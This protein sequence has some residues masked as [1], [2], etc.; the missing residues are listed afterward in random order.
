MSDR[1]GLQKRGHRHGDVP[2]S[3]EEKAGREPRPKGKCSGDFAGRATKK[4]SRMADYYALIARTVV[5]L[6]VN[7]EATRR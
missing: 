3:T 7:T 6:K 4:G 5:D 1:S 2:N